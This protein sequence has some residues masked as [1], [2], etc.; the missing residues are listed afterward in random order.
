MSLRQTKTSL[1]VRNILS[2]YYHLT[3]GS[4]EDELNLEIFFKNPRKIKI[5]KM[6]SICRIEAIHVSRSVI[7]IFISSPPFF[8]SPPLPL[9]YRNVWH[10]SSWLGYE[11]K[12]LQMCHSFKLVPLPHIFENTFVYILPNP[13][14]KIIQTYGSSNHKSEIR[15]ELQRGWGLLA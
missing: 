10:C 9:S 14:I 8:S 11:L 7:Y 4:F 5:V 1:L 15:L 3:F 2:N 6:R 13:P 12:Y